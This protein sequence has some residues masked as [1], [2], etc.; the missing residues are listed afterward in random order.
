MKRKPL[1]IKQ[2][3]AALCT[4]LGAAAA[5]TAVAS[6][7]PVPSALTAPVTIAQASPV[8]SPSP[9]ATPT[10]KPLSLSAFADTGYQ[11]ASFASAPNTPCNANFYGGPTCGNAITG[12]V[13]DNTNNTPQLHNFNLTAAYAGPIGGKVELSFGDDADIIAS[14]PKSLHSPPLGSGTQV[15]LTQAYLSFTGGAVSVLL[16]KFETLAGAEVIENT[17]N[18]NYSRSILFGYA[19]P[20][21]HTGGRVTVAATPKLNL[22]AGLNKGWDT[23]STLSANNDSNSLTLELGGAWTPSKAFG[24]TAQGYTGKV[25]QGGNLLNM[26]R[27]LI[28]FVATFHATDAL[29]FVLNGD[30]GSQTNVPGIGTAHWD[31]VAGYVNYA[32]SPKFSAALRGEF[33]NDQ[34]G[35]RTGL[36]QQWKEVTLSGTYNLTSNL[37]VRGEVR[38]DRSNKLFFANK[39]GN[40]YKTNRQLGI[41]VLAHT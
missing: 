20:F 19:V 36:V 6:A 10:P 28:D 13:F 2:R 14:Y 30:N 12:R 1:T 33:F 17:G 18:Y 24:L 38:G 3:L 37:F 35:F 5:L 39:D 15:D 22:I 25:P 34:Q 26:N 21:T 8:P 31:G 9:S 27:G 40:F 11:T 23:T 29:T 16:G 41:E 32:F 7:E 4:A